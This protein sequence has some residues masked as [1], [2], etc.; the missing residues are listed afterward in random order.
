[1]AHFEEA[2]HAQFPAPEGRKVAGALADSG[3]AREV[4]ELAAGVRGHRFPLLGLTVETGAEI[5]WRRDYERGIESAPDYF[6][7]IPYLDTSRAGDH[8]LIWELNRHQHLVTLA[9][10]YLFT[11]EQAN[12]EEICAQLETWFVQNPYARGINW[13]STLEVALRSL[14]WMWVYHFVGRELPHEF[15]RRWLGAIYSHA[16][17]IENNLSVYFSPNTHLLG[18]ALA[19][20]V[21]G[22]FFRPL[23]EARCW[24][25]VGARILREQMDRQ[26]H[27]DGSHIE[28]S[29]Y[30]HLYALDMFLLHAILAK[31]DPAY[32]DKLGRMVSYLDSVLGPARVLPFLGDDDGGRLF[33]PYGAREQFGRASMA[34]AAAVLH[35]E[36]CESQEEDLYAQAYWW[37]GPVVAPPVAAEGRASHLFPDAG[38]A[39]LVAGQNHIIVN[40]GSFGPW[41]AGHSHAGALSIIARS[42]AEE[43]LIDAGTYTY[44]GDAAWRDWFRGAEAHNTIRINQL[45]QATSTGPFRW[46][47]H[48][49]VKVIA[50][51]SNAERDTLEA[52]CCYRGFT[53]RRRIDFEKP[54]LLIVVDEVAG[55]AGEHEVEQLWHLGS[56][57][58]RVRL[59]LADGAE[60]I[61]SW[62]ST[63]F[64]AK[65]PAP[66]M[67]VRRRG[68]LPL[69]LEARIQLS[70]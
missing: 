21:L 7:R 37:L 2:W 35:R 48:P 34:T 64:G 60:C 22:L 43:V 49:R 11:G 5:R 69:R 28:K 42:A 19:L 67:R 6:R 30:Y 25:R 40:A 16:R 55:P 63:A 62:R 39:I 33:H 14:S 10:A 36:D 46:K 29:T 1:M 59:A 3:F 47:D 58:A 20:H 45:D 12:L 52:E 41:G 13:A 51:D 38:L 32:W 17:F 65:F 70:P 4:I 56:P 50:W 23:P 66:L 68:Q 24:E 54:G 31:P 57:D 8:K 26:V 18:E 53:H 61:E 27:N 15:R 9:Q 44:T